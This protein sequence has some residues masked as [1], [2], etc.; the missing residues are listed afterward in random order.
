MT[1]PADPVEAI[2]W[3]LDPT[4]ADDRAH[5]ASPFTRAVLV[6]AREA[7]TRAAPK[8]K[9]MPAGLTPAEMAAW[10]FPENPTDS[11]SYQRAV[12]AEP[13]AEMS[14]RDALN[15]LRVHAGHASGMRADPDAA[16]PARDA[17][18]PTGWEL[19]AAQLSALKE[20]AASYHKLM[21]LFAA[22]RMEH[23]TCQPRARRACTHCNAV[24]DIAAMV[25]AY[26]GPMVVR[27][28]AAARQERKP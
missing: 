14:Y 10:R 27:S 3:L 13:V 6:K 7:L 25:K 2:D 20:D 28:D 8:A 11:R 4:A 22:T 21:G 19:T 24:D 16:P 5:H 23:G 18:L 12:K 9:P 17:V 15:D 26:A 1:I